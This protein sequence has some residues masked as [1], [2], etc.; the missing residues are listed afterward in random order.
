MRKKKEEKERRKKEEEYVCRKLE[1]KD[2][3][4]SKKEKAHGRCK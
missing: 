4:R 3:M 2:Y 1:R